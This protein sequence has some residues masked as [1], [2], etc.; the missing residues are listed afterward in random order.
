MKL[1]ELDLSSFIGNHAAAKVRGG[2]DSVRGKASGNLSTKD[3]MAKDGFIKDFVGRAAANIQSAIEGGLVSAEP[4]QQPASPEVDNPPVAAT[5][6]PATAAP[7]TAAPA[8]AA[9]ATAAPATAAPGTPA[10]GAS[11]FAQMSRQLG[12][13]GTSS[14]GGQTTASA[15]GVKHTANPNNPNQ[16]KPTVA[17]VASPPPVAAAA[18]RAGAKSRAMGQQR[19]FNKGSAIKESYDILNAL[20]ESIMEADSPPGISSYLQKMFTQYMKGVDISS[21]AARI[22]TL[23]NAV[24]QTYAKDG[25]KAALTQL[26]NLGF[27]MSYS[28]KGTSSAKSSPDSGASGLASSFASGLSGAATGAATDISPA[29]AGATASTFDQISA[30]VKNMSPEDK[31]KLIAI[32]QAPSQAELDADQARMA[33][34]T[35]ESRRRVR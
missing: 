4:T 5:A 17:P 9:P 33:T 16:P 28:N 1:N 8:T 7:A 31:K 21:E 3:R 11:A 14:T 35:N 32:L 20:F 24:E 27:A 13:S 18:D 25:G 30:Q 12:G 15:T 26:A 10:A 34:G 6:A 22:R 19:R 2:L 23:C 29:A